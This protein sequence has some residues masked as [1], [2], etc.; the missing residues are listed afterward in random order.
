[1]NRLVVRGMAFSVL[2]NLMVK[3]VWILGVELAVQRAVG[4]QSY[5]Q[6][7]SLFNIT[8]L[9]L[10]VLDLGITN[11]NIRNIA[12]H[13]QLLNKHLGGLTILKLILGMVYLFVLLPVGYMLNNDSNSLKI[14]FLLGLAQMFNSFTLYFRSNLSAL[15]RFGWDAALSVAD[16]LLLIIFCSIVLLGIGGI[17]MDIFLFAKLQMITSFI[18]MLIAATANFKVAGSIKLNFNPV[19]YYSILR[20]S[21]PFAT[22]VMIM[23][24]YTK[25]DAVLLSYLLE[26]ASQAG[27]YAAGYRL[28][29]AY[30][31]FA[32]IATGILYPF[33]SRS[34]KLGQSVNAILGWSIRL[35]ISSAFFLTIISLFFS[36]ELAGLF[37][38]EHVRE[39]A[40]V[41]S[42]LMFVSVP[43]VLSIVAGSYITAAGRIRFLIQVALLCAFVNIVLNIIFIPSYGAI[44]SAIIAVLTQIVSASVLIYFI[45]KRLQFV[46]TT[47]WIIRLSVLV[48]T[49]L[50]GAFVISNQ[51]WPIVLDMVMMLVIF[52]IALLFT[53]ILDFK[54]FYVI[55]KSNVDS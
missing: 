49:L 39:T 28:F 26:D 55:F 9:F 34:I 22:L 40:R 54:M 2:L 8:V 25:S 30:A 24:I 3:S 4:N 50:S 37:Y 20:Q 43:Y 23:S 19:F 7:Y 32:V 10:I 35:L 41:L 6:Y 44:A 48:L 12:Q 51:S 45:A 27:I 29:D 16:R 17:S 15:L 53:R 33:F 31:Q 42:V 38:K 52:V 36:N 21:F 11:F 47:N 14:L 46:N 1:M 5:G 18:T 13:S